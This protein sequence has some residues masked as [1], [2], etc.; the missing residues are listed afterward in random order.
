MH[1]ASAAGSQA[2]AQLIQALIQKPQQKETEL[3]TKLAKI[4][5]QM[6]TASAANNQDGVG[7][8]LDVTV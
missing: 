8:S 5:L 6:K 2:S 1:G 7:G 3:A 4:S